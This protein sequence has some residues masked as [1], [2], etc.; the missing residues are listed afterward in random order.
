[1]TSELQLTSVGVGRRVGH[2]G[3]NHLSRHPSRPC[4]L[5]WGRRYFQR[6][7]LRGDNR[8]GDYVG[9]FDGTFCKGRGGRGSLKML[10]S[11]VE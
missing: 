2:S 10:F 1:M 7:G 3:L 4:R 5:S 6:V 8:A 9:G 11:V